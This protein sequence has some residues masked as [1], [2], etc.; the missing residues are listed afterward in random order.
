M[1]RV[2]EQVAILSSYPCVVALVRL[3]SDTHFMSRHLTN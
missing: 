2:F 1:N 3:N